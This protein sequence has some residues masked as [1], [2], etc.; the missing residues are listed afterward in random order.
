MAMHEA[1][2]AQSRCE[3]VLHGLGFDT[4][5]FDRPLDE[6][7]GGYRMRVSLARLLL[8]RPDVL[9]LDEPT[10]HLDITS[11]DWLEQFLKG[12]KGTMVLVSHDRYFLNRMTNAIAHLRHGAVT[13]YAGNYDYF[14]EERENRRV[15]EQAAYDNQQREIAQTKRFIARF[16]YKAS[17]ARQVQS[18]IK[19]LDRMVQLQP[20]EATEAEIRIRFPAP[21]RSGRSVLNLSRFS[22]A[23][24]TDQTAVQVFDDAGPLIIERGDKIALIGKNGAGKSTLARILLGTEPFEGERNLGYHV[25]TTF[26]AQHQADALTAWPYRIGIF[27]GSVIEHGGE[28]PAVNPWGISVYGR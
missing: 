17:K 5:D 11:I 19:S 8:Q 27:T 1:H 25:E 2:S 16:R 18:R 20:P 9:L 14:L 22:K 26:F 13:E 21:R 24:R 4:E 6:L 23:Y 10:N 3:S 7:S 15:L 28:I 12:Y